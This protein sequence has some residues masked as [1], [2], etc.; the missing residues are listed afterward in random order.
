MYGKVKIDKDLLSGFLTAVFSFA[1]SEVKSAGV[2]SIVMGGLQWLYDYHKG[3]LFI[4]AADKIDDI[5]LLRGQLDIVRA[6]FLEKFS[7]FKTEGDRA[8]KFLRRWNG[9][10]K[11]F[12]EFQDL[13]DDYV[14]SWKTA[15]ET[16]RMANRMDFLEVVQHILDEISTIP[17][18]MFKKVDLVA[19]Q[20]K[21]TIN[22]DPN[23]K[24]VQVQ[25]NLKVSI[26]NLS[27]EV[28]PEDF[29]E[30]IK[31][32]V[33]VEIRGMK[34]IFGPKKLQSVLNARMVLYL[35]RDWRRIKSLDL[36]DFVIKNTI[37]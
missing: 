33:K 29:L 35:K 24:G 21:K 37:V 13:L 20:M 31:R 8:M 7:I 28:S 25:P 10:P 15:T 19:E 12:K 27:P 30:S 34:E 11:A 36:A 5:E 26:T 18:P 23:L 4:I 14:G 2:E 3:L 9:S 17:I 1:E 6:S 32:L 22:D 16:A